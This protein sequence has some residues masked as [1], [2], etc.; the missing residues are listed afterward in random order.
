MMPRK[1]KNHN[2]FNFSLSEGINAVG[3]N[4]LVTD[5]ELINVGVLLKKSTVQMS[6]ISITGQ[7]ADINQ[8]SLDTIG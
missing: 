8:N 7:N 3:N 6:G 5:T 1:F 2:L 4:I